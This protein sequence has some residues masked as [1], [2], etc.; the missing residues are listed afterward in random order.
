MAKFSNIF[1]TH[2]SSPIFF[3]LNLLFASYVLISNRL[4]FLNSTYLNTLMLEKP[5]WLFV[6]HQIESSHL[7]WYFIF[8]WFPYPPVPFFISISSYYST[9]FKAFL[10]FFPILLHRHPEG[11]LIHLAPFPPISQL[12]ST[13]ICC[14]Q[15]L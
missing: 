11:I 12:W 10:H 4:A 15:R 9:H 7:A 3:S 8:Q 14:S 6:A 5:R 1:L 13:K 2:L